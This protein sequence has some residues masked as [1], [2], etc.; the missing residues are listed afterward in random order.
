MTTKPFPNDA[1]RRRA[2]VVL[3]QS[4]IDRCGF[5]DG[6]PALLLN[7]E[8]HVLES[9]VRDPQGIIRDI[10][11]RGLVQRGAILAQSPFDKDRYE[12]AEQAKELFALA[13]HTHFST[14]CMHLG[15]REVKIEQIR[16]KKTSE[17]KTWTV[18]GGVK[19]VNASAS[20]QQDEP[21]DFTSRLTLVDTFE[22]GQANLEAAEKLLRQTGLLGDPNMSGLLD[23]RR[24]G[25]NH[26][27][28]KSRTLTLNLSSEAKR[29]LTIIGN[30]QLPP[31]IKLKA[32]YTS[33]IREQSEYTLTITVCF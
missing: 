20:V 11:E 32:D 24:P 28:L 30:L 18:E 10:L 12:D 14:F 19:V 9:P 21:D 5:E 17:T 8:I 1:Q 29:N 25:S 26:N 33:V 15:A 27:W 22:G 7:E 6:G 23:M 4:D 3:D 31:F 13:K 16:L 2:I